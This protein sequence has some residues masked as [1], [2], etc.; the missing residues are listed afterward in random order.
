MATSNIGVKEGADKFLATY[1]ISEDAITKQIQRASINNSSGVELG[2]TTNPFVVGGILAD[3]A[4]MSTTKLMAVGGM[5]NAAAPTYA[6]GDAGFLQIDANGFLK[7][8]NATL[9]FGED[10]T[11]NTQG[12]TQKVIVASTYSPSLYTDLTQVTKA[13]IKASAGVVMSFTITNDN[14]AVRYFQLHNKASAPAAADV[15]LYSWKV[16]AGTANNPGF[17]EIGTEFF[18]AAGK[19]FTTGIGWAI[20]TTYGTFTDSATNTE[21][22]TDVHYF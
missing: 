16:G 1:S 22:I 2:T 19:Y 14:A 20:S 10:A 6:D 8:T 13:N 18:T 15:P 3:N 4:P 7:I 11:N 12:V 17:L 21:H 9:Q 5:F